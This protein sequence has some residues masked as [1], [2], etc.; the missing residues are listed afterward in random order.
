MR[1]RIAILGM[2]LAVGLML[3]VRPATADQPH[4]EAALEALKSAES[5]LEKATAD[6][7]GH[8]EAALRATSSAMEHV[9]KGMR[10]DEHHESKKE[11]RN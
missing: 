1:T 8:R 11:R 6:K 5:H 3:T 7:G 4:M 2:S 10:Y 9:R